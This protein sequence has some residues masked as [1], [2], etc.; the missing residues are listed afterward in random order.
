MTDTVDL[1]TTGAELIEAAR[2]EGRDQAVR[3]VVSQPG[4]RLILLGLPAGGGLPDHD[5]PGP[6]ALQCLT[7][8]VVLTAG[9]RSWR[10]P[11][12]SAVQIPQE[13]HSVAAAVDSVC[14]LAVSL[15]S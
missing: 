2:A 9:G 15:P 1:L 4:Q 5:A 13:T 14:V 12:G 7:G 3:A 6:A 10:L 8:E 11:A